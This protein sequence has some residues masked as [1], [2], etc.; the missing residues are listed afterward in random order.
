[1]KGMDP[2]EAT[3]RGLGAHREVDFPV[4]IAHGRRN[5]ASVVKERIARRF[6]RLAS[7]IVELVHPLKF[8]LDDALIFALHDLRLEVVA[9]GTTGDF[10]KS[11]H[12]IVGREDIVEDRAR[13]DMAWPADDTR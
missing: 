3:V 9:L 5:R 1:M 12:P 11:R 13:L 6:L 8:G 2:Q 4:L 7:Q 10:D